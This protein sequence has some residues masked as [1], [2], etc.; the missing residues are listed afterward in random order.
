MHEID[1]GKLQYPFGRHTHELHIGKFNH[2]HTINLSKE[3]GDDENCT[4]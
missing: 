2:T 4:E 1:D 3:T